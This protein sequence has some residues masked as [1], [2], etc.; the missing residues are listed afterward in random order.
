MFGNSTQN[1]VMEARC[2]PSTQCV[3]KHMM[4]CSCCGRA[5]LFLQVLMQQLE[6]PIC[7]CSALVGAAA[8]LPRSCNCTT[9]MSTSHNFLSHRSPACV[10]PTWP[11]IWP[12]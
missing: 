3:N 4:S 2:T 6:V 1:G 12:V 5:C 11:R 7:V 8:Y 10:N 9:C